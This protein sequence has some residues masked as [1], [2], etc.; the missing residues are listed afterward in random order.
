MT[1]LPC[2]TAVLPP[3]PPCE[4]T[5]GV[6]LAR[7]AISLHQLPR[8]PQ[9][10]QPTQPPQPR[11]GAGAALQGWRQSD[12]ALPP[13]VALVPDAAAA[14]TGSAGGAG[15][16]AS[17]HGLYT[18][19]ATEPGPLK[20]QFDGSG[21]TKGPAVLRL[22]LL[23]Q[24]GWV[25]WDEETDDPN[26]WHLHWRSGRFKPSHYRLALPYQRLNHLPRSSLITKKDSLQK[27]LRRFKGVYGSV[28]DFFPTGFMLPTEYTKFLKEYRTTEQEQPIWICKPTDLSRG[29]KIFLIRN[30]MELRYDH[31]TI[32]QRVRGAWPLPR[33]PPSLVALRKATH[34]AALCALW[35]VQY[36]ADPLTVGGYKLDLRLYVLVTS[37]HPLVRSA[38]VRPPRRAAS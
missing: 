11:C 4:L 24:R 1:T 3:S 21:P 2:G 36:I 5:S 35:P 18:V 30:L 7:T 9:A 34:P 22:V 38:T 6:V 17:A 32:I 26:D 13:A 29:R 15:T 16:G 14:R 23:D 28:Y 33:P 12:M 10:S 27:S 20:V 25:E 37:C 8:R 19:G 31:S